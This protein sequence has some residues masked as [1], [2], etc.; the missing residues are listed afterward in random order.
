MLLRR[1]G[2]EYRELVDLQQSQ[3]DLLG[4]RVLVVC[5]RGGNGGDGF[6]AARHLSNIGADVDTVL[7][8]AG[9]FFLSLTLGSELSGDAAANYEIHKAMNLP[10]VECVT[11]DLPNVDFVGYNLI[12]DGI[13]GT[14]LT[15]AVS[16]TSPSHGSSLEDCNR[17]H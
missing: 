12:I 4:S 9:L 14:G 8:A 7:L 6:V 15:R 16:G 2:G 11:D 5:G 3:N 10:L 17:T 13:Y 1:S